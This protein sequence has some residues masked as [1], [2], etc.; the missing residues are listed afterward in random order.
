MGCETSEYFEL[1]GNS[2]RTIAGEVLPGAV[3][4]RGEVLDTNDQF[5]GHS[6]WHSVEQLTYFLDRV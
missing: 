6:V 5:T 4:A 1:D 2:A 3:G